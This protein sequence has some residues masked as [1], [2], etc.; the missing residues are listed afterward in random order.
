MVSLV[1]S[2]LEFAVFLIQDFPLKKKKQIYA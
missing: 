2:D 1:N